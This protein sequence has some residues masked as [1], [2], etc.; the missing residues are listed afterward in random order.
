MQAWVK[1]GIGLPKGKKNTAADRRYILL[2]TCGDRFLSSA[3]LFVGSSIGAQPLQS[4]QAAEAVIPVFSFFAPL[5]MSD[6]NLPFAESIL[7]SRLCYVQFFL[8]NPP[9]G[10]YNSKA[11]FRFYIVSSGC[12]AAGSAHGSGP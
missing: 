7:F 5:P 9:C 8:D 3:L 11:V 2:R 10:I 12:S 4:Q 1:C 6:I